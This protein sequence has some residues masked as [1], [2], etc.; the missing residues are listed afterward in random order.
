MTIAWNGIFNSSD[1]AGWTGLKKGQAIPKALRSVHQ[2]PGAKDSKVGLGV[3]RV[4]ANILTGKVDFGTNGTG[5][6]VSYVR[7]KGASVTASR[8]GLVNAI[9]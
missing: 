7:S 1:G 5:V 2:P 3:V 6:F 9:Q 4:I 8:G